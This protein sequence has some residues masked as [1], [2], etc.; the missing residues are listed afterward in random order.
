VR[1][2]IPLKVINKIPTKTLSYEILSSYQK[3]LSPN[4]KTPACNAF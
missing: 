1:G 4:R 3:R 2:C